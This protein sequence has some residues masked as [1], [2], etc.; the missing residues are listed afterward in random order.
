MTILKKL[1]WKIVLFTKKIA[2]YLYEMKGITF[3][4]T[5]ALVFSK[6]DLAEAPMLAAVSLMDSPVFFAPPCILDSNLLQLSINSLV[7][8]EFPFFSFLS[9]FPGCWR[10]HA[11]HPL[12][13]F[14]YELFSCTSVTEQ[15]VASW[16][17]SYTCM[18]DIS[19]W[20]VTWHEVEV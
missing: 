7:F 5:V 14:R 9:L 10:P 13:R 16:R 3:S 8:Y 19:C 17:Y 1:N 15:V 11:F 6:P 12:N 18:N 20:M 4:W 2:E